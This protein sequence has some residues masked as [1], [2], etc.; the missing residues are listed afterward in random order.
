MSGY[1]RLPR[2]FFSS[3]LWKEA[4][5][6]SRA[7]AWLD[8]YQSAN[9]AP[10]QHIAEGRCLSLARG[11]LVAS[12]RYLSKR[13]SWSR[14]RVERYLRLIK[15]PPLSLIE[16]RAETGITIVSI[17][18]YDT[19][20]ASEP[21]AETPARTRPRQPRDKEK[22]RKEKKETLSP[23][24]APAGG[25]EKESSFISLPT[26]EE[27][28][29]YAASKPGYQPSAIASLYHYNA[30]R[31]WEIGGKTVRNWR[32]LVDAWFEKNA[33]AAATQPQSI[34]KAPPEPK[35]WQSRMLELYPQSNPAD[36]S[37]AQLHQKYPDIA[38][39]LTPKQNQA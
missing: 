11:E 31:G 25:G 10:G 16:T 14:G 5:P 39:Q 33:P 35:G 17:R 19:Y 18:N 22:E 24:K 3:P 2:A 9:Y 28:H 27:W 29:R 12:V 23:P 8:L 30:A 20:T 6:Y 1:I 21:P 36:F 26:L 13:W 4:R 37:W 38:Q 7:E 34:A 15:S 32:S